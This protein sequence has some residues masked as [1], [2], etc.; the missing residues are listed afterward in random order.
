MNLSELNKDKKNSRKPAVDLNTMVYGK[1]PPQARELEEAVLGAIM[2]EKGAYEK[3]SEVLHPECFYLE[4]HQRIYRAMQTLAAA[5]QPIDILTVTDRL[6]TGKE[7]EIVG[8]AFYVTKLTNN[9]VSA[10]NLSAHARIIFRKYLGRELIR[11]S[12]EVIG[13]A[14]EEDTDPFEL[15][16]TL[17]RN[18]SELAVKQTGNKFRTLHEVA[19][20]SVDRIYQAKMSGNELTG[21]PS[22]LPQIDNLTQGFQRTNFIIIAAR[23]G[24]G[25]SAVAGNLA[26]NAATHPAA[27][28][29]V[30]IFSLEMS[31]GQWADRILSASTRITLH[32]LK[33]GRVDD[34]EMKRLQNAALVDYPK[35]P[36]FIDDS[37][38]LTLSQFK[39]KCR[40][41]VLQHGVGFILYDY[42]QL[43]DGSR[44]RGES[45]EQEV[46]RC[47]REMK[48]LA[49]ELNVQIIALSQLS[50]AGDTEEPRL[51]HLRE[52]GAI[53]QDADDV[54]F[55]VPVS[56]E[57][58]AADASLKDSIL[59]VFAKHR[60]GMLERVPL[61]FVKSIQKLMTENEY[62]KYMT[63]RKLP[64]T[65]WMPVNLPFNDD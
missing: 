62:E 1:L 53:E 22:G 51:S 9:V 64:G 47:S 61:K 27:P 49:K 58:A 40:T 59:W 46:A 33:R 57:E 55:L 37:P 29:G 16:E 65:G 26:I 7:L 36:I 23:P 32:N 60:N 38:N 24:V 52:S 4:G 19:K 5:N 21:V 30:A 13:D 50:R 12:G 54:I 8:G 63:G 48:Q 3:A 14:Y 11:I 43:T 10:A 20:E 28:T 41:L 39:R 45:R 34:E 6:M 2:L 31:A 42:L 18:I 35:I 15:L 25:K 17:E 56:D 44:Q